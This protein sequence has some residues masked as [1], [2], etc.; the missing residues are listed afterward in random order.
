MTTAPALSTTAETAAPAESPLS[1][2]TTRATVPLAKPPVQTAPAAA[3]VPAAP[4]VSYKSCADAR[5]A[6][7]APLHRGDPGY[8]SGLDKDGDGTACE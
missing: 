6:G 2:I 3:P 5:A 7:A 4:V 8:R 1:S